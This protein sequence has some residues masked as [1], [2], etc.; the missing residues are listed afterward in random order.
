M[1]KIYALAAV[2]MMAATA[3]AQDGA[4]LYIVGN[5]ENLGWNPAEPA[6]FTFAD[7]QYTFESTKILQ[8]KISTTKGETEN[9]WEG[10]NAGALGCGEAGYGSEKDAVV[11]LVPWGENTMCPW[12][13]DYT[14]TVA[15]DL[16]T[17]KLSTNT[18]KPDTSNPELY[19]LGDMNGWGGQDAWKLSEVGSTNDGGVVYT[20]V[21]DGIMIAAGEG[22]KVSTQP[23]NDLYN[24]GAPDPIILDVECEM[25]C[26]G[27]SP[28]SN[29]EEDW[30]GVAYLKIG[31]PSAPAMIFL[32]NDKAAANPW[33]EEM[34]NAVS[35][36]AAENGVASYYTIEGVRVANPENG[37]YIVVKDG[38]AS[39][40]LVK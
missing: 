8:F 13:G 4:P 22:F 18:P 25:E 14:I 9:D 32:S 26:G 33:A 6:E 29:V 12:A 11:A 27:G 38:K 1:K 37:L 23:W 17:I 21:C 40:V 15:G 16:S 39:K 34:V 2:A 5:G 7:G 3:M 28:N 10:F 24:Y 35:T 31:E 19:F 36:I 30:D 20:L